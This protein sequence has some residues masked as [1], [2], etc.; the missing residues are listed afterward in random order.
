[1]TISLDDKIHSLSLISDRSV[2]SQSS[3]NR[4]ISSFRTP[5]SIDSTAG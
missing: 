2:G 1:M 3:D 4:L 5:H